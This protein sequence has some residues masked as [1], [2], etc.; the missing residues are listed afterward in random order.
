MYVTKTSK[1][2]VFDNAFDSLT[3]ETIEEFLAMQDITSSSR[4]TYKNV[5]QQ[6]F[7]WV[8]TNNKQQLSR[9]SILTYK[10][11]LDEKSISVF[12]KSLYL[13]VVRRFF[14]WTEEQNIYPNITQGIKNPKK[15]SK[16]HYKDS[17]RV[18]DIKLLFNT[19][20]TS[21]LQGK[22]DF[23]II[24]LLLRTGLRLREVT[25]ARIHDI[26][27]IHGKAR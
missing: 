8:A 22:R 20:D 16:S 19:I 5:L 17:L 25:H 14:T 26:E 24:N 12:T 18:E 2:N 7:S 4:S 23:A 21:N 9:L 15:Q 11:W 6:F 3:I 27:H 1:K 13:V 10:S